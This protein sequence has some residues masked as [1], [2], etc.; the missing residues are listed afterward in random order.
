MEKRMLHTGVAQGEVGRY[1]LIPGRVERA[2]LISEYFD[3][4]RLLCQNREFLTYVGATALTRMLYLPNSRARDLVMPLTAY[5][6]AG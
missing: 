2:K 5:L 6:E 1:V 3:E 4:P